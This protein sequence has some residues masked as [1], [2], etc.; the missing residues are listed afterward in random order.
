MVRTLLTAL[1]LRESVERYP[2]VL[3]VIAGCLVFSAFCV[4]RLPAVRLPGGGGHPLRRLSIL[5]RDPLFGYICAVWMCLG[6]GNLATLPLRVD[7]LANP[8]H[9]LA[10][11]PWRV[12]L[13]TL[14]LPQ[15]VAALVMPAWGKAFDRMN[16]IALRMLLNACFAVSIIAFF[17]PALWA[18]ALGAVTFGLGLGGGQ[19]AWN[20]WVT[21]FAP[22]G[23]THD[24]MT[25]HTFLTGCRGVSSPL[26]AFGLVHS[27]MAIRHVAYGGTILVV[28][29][30]VLLIPVLKYGRREQVPGTG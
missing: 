22:E 13:L 2:A 30:I 9:G 27:G 23:K 12:L 24:Y 5:W 4:L 3:V 11:A 26:V 17:I 15:L 14:V 25:V 1:W 16:F 29:S 18:Q 10:Y 28:L 19:V 6:F 7:Y 8:E 20:L 21:R